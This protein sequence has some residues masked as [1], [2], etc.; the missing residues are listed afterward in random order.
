VAVRARTGNNVHA[1]LQNTNT[2][3]RA[4]ELKEIFN[5]QRKN[6]QAL[7]RKKNDSKL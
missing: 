2:V 5:G 4:I 3:R 1:G 6:A 7:K